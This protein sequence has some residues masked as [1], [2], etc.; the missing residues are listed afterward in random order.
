MSTTFSDAIGAHFI[1]GPQGTSLSPDE[2]NLFRRLRP[3]GVFLHGANFLKE[4]S[5]REWIVAIA[6]LLREAQELSGRER[7]IVCIDHEGGRIMRTPKPFTRTPAAGEFAPYSEIVGKIHG[8]ELAS[9]GVNLSFGPVVDVYSNPANPVIG[10]RSFADTPEGVITAARAYVRGLQSSG[11]ACCLKHFPGHGDTLQD[12]HDGFATVDAPREVLQSRELRPFQA[13]VAEGSV[14]AIMTAH[15]TFPAVDAGVPATLSSKILQGIL[16]QEF[17]YDGVVISDDIDM[18]AMREHFSESETARRAAQAGVDILLFNHH[19]ARALACA[20]ALQQAVDSG[21]IDPVQFARSSS[22]VLAML[23]RLSQH[24]AKEMPD[25]FFASHQKLLRDA[26]AALATDT[27]ALGSEPKPRVLSVPRESFAVR[28]G[29]VIEGDQRSKLHFQLERP[30]VAR[31]SDGKT[32]T[33]SAATPYTIEIRENELYLSGAEHA[34]TK[35]VGIFKVAH[36]GGSELRPGAGIR[37]GPIVAGRH[38]HWK[39]DIEATFTGAI[40]FHPLDDL[41]I[42]VNVLDYETY[43]ACVVGSEMSGR[44]L[45]AEF[46]KAQATAARS[47]AYVFLGNKYPGKPYTVCN[48][49]M[50]QRYQGTSH[51]SEELIAQLKPCAGRYLVD[52][53]GHVVA[54]YYSKSTGGHGER[55][56][57]IFGFDVP[58]CGANFD[59]PAQLAPRLDLREEADFA[60]WLEESSSRGLG[61]Y[62]SP[63][64]VSDEALSQLLGAVDTMTKYY[65]WT[66]TTSAVTVLKNLREKFKVS[67][68]VALEEISFGKRGVSGRYLDATLHYRDAS[69]A[70]RIF[71]LPNQFAIRGCLHESFLFSSAFQCEIVRSGNDISELRFRG[72]GWGHGA[73]F[74][75]IGGLGMALGSAQLEPQSYEA[76]LKHYYPGARLVSAY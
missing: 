9:L 3:I 16:R 28:V 1:V 10:P 54:G 69:G 5:Y 2:K 67:D 12:T 14:P 27:P 31:A 20:E 29:V 43:I 49:D 44:G 38:F 25:T 62:C 48:D 4:K 37:L 36:E 13:L 52:S 72:A 47:W 18:G 23:A 70:K 71:R 19:P 24:T 8:E 11:V 26:R 33:L 45:P 59:C 41:I 40:E 30:T 21:A 51:I 15:V 7:M 50:S 56:E 68:A 64:V 55:A 75:Q 74:C 66:H 35:I 53:L 42:A 34:Q 17:K 73:G 22:R 6:A 39:K 61:I 65:R 32:F 63:E 60:R 46:S 57:N 58:G 76:I